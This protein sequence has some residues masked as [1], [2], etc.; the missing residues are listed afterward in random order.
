VTLSAFFACMLALADPAASTA[1]QRPGWIEQLP[2][3]PGRI[4]ALGTADLSPSSPEGRALAQASDR[5]RLEVIARLRVSV[6]GETSTTARTTQ[7]GSGGRSYGYGDRSSRDT[8]KVGTQ[9]EDLP[10][11]SV[12]QTYVDAS[13]HTAY[14]LAVLDLGLAETS[15]QVR[16][17]GLEN[18]RRNLE[19]ERSRPARWRLR[20][21]QGDLSRLAELAS[22]LALEAMGDRIQSERTMVEKRL[23]ALEA[24]ELPP[25]DLAKCAMALRPNITLP[26]AL[27]AF[28]SSRITETGLKLR[29][30]GADFRLELTFNGPSQGPALI[31]AE[32]QFVGTILYRIEA[33]A[34]IT[35][36]GGVV[37]AKAPPISLCQEGSAEGLTTQFQRQFERRW[38][39]LMDQLL[40]ELK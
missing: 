37:L 6:K 25:L 26:P 32:P 4:Y 29:D 11:L 36:A 40:G 28:L 16:L 7:L 1:I 9:A 17:R 27:D 14:A 33:S 5:A 38:G 13:S 20:R 12:E 15:L 19:G 35:D 8:V 10:G 18:S 39:M 22:L 3:G 2:T 24:E 21:L 31:F 23:A 34:Q 30:A